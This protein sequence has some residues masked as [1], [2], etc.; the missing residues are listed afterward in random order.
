M[1]KIVEIRMF[2]FPM[3]FCKLDYSL[4]FLSELMEDSNTV[5]SKRLLAIFSTSTLVTVFC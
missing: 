3:W 2:D 4:D 1:K 5:H